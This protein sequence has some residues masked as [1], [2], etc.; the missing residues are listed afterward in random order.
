MTHWIASRCATIGQISGEVR[1]QREV[2]IAVLDAEVATETLR[3]DAWDLGHG[4]ERIEI[5]GRTVRS[6]SMSSDS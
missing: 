6:S 4:Y 1:L 2:G 3:R 5:P